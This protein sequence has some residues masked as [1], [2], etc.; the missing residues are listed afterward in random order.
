MPVNLILKKIKSFSSSYNSCHEM[1]EL[2]LYCICHKDGFMDD[3]YF[4]CHNQIDIH[5]LKIK[6]N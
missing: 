2:L 1:L 3:I 6:K 4:S 5:I